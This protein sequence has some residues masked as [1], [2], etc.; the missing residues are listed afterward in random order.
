MTIVHIAGVPMATG[1][2]RCVRCC[3]V[4]YRTPHAFVGETVLEG[5]ADDV[6]RHCTPVDLCPRETEVPSEYSDC[7]PNNCVGVRWALDRRELER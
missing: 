6:R 4:L 2:Q 1:E 7:Y 3:E 5:S